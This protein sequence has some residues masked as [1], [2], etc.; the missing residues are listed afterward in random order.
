MLKSGLVVS[1]GGL[2]GN[3]EIVGSENGG[4]IQGVVTAEQK[5]ASG[6]SVVVVP[7]AE[8][9]VRNDLVRQVSVDQNGA[10]LITGVAPGKYRVFALETV[11]DPGVFLDPR[12]L[13]RLGDLGQPLQVDEKGMVRLDLKLIL[14]SQYS[15]LPP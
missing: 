1:E 3:I 15:R 9:G 12:F 2:G 11:D 14:E 4:K 5:P 13:R 6:A 7:D 10:F 8:G